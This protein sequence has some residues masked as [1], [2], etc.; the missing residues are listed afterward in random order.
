MLNESLCNEDYLKQAHLSQVDFCIK[1][2]FAVNRLPVDVYEK[3]MDLRERDPDFMRKDPVQ[4]DKF[5]QDGDANFFLSEPG[6]GYEELEGNPV[7]AQEDDL[8]PEG[9]QDMPH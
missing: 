3:L 6:Q 5:L 7:H 1:R 4:S 9:S 2:L 8:P